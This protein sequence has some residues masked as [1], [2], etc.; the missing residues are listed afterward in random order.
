MEAM[1]G[2]LV[3]TPRAV[4]GGH[5]LEHGSRGRNVHLSWRFLDDAFL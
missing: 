3:E 2:L 1:R 5:Y 4:N